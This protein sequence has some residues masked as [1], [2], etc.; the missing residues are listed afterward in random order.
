MP[1]RSGLWRLLRPYWKLLAVAFTA[2]LVEGAADLFEPWPLKIVFDS[3]IGSK[4]VPHALA[5]AGLAGSPLRLLNAAALTVIMV[6][7]VGAMSSYVEKYL[8][9]TVGQRVMHDLR[10][11]LYHHV[12]R[13]SLSYYEQT[14]NEHSY[15]SDALRSDFAVP[16]ISTMTFFYDSFYEE[17]YDNHLTIRT[18]EPR[19]TLDAQ[20]TPFYELKA[21]FS[22]LNLHYKQ[23]L[24]DRG[25]RD[26]KLNYEHPPDTT[27]TILDDNFNTFPQNTDATSH[28]FAG[29]A[30]NIFQ[31]SD[32]TFVNAGVRVDYFAINRDL[33][34]S[35]RLSASHILDNGMT[36]RAAWGYYYQSPIYTQLAYSVPSDTNTQSQKAEHYVLSMEQT[37]GG[38]G[39]NA[40]TWKVEGYYKKYSNLVSST[41]SNTGQIYYSRKNDADGY[42]TGADLF[43]SLRVPGYYGWLSYGLLFAYEDLRTDDEGKYPRYTDQR[44]TLSMVNDIDLGRQWSLNLRLTYGSGFAYTPFQIAYSSFEGRNVWVEGKKNSDH[45]PEYKRVDARLSREFT[46]FGLPAYAFLDVSNL[47]NFTNIFAFRYRYDGNGQP[48]REEVDL[49]PILPSLGLTVRF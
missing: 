35:P 23:D 17:Q 4:P 3:V 19:I 30:E 25:L 8:S 27:E 34:I 44:H 37:G 9:T 2:M 6:A 33:T 45:L 41:Q 39:G 31:L 38:E 29:Y 24:I 7:A 13:L 40:F 16:N 48:Y 10:H 26:T 12:Q 28:K 32:N 46:L 11:M 47:F 21:G 22:Y 20:V 18:L 1:L 49:W 5:W 36:V 15:S 43:V 14:D 42:A